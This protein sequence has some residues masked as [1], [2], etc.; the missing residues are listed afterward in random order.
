M[1]DN[2]IEMAKAA[3]AKAD[4]VRLE[5]GDELY[6]LAKLVRVRLALVGEGLAVEYHDREGCAI[7]Y[8]VELTR[9]N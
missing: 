8:D 2:P 3:L 4:E 9:K 1:N 5:P 7:L 6:E